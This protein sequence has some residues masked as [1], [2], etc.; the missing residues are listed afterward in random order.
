MC[1][2]SPYA[3][4]YTIEDVYI[5]QNIKQNIR[6]QQNRSFTGVPVKEQQDYFLLRAAPIFNACHMQFEPLHRS[7][8]FFSPR[9]VPGQQSRLIQISW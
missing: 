7:A 2:A 5:K 9:P 3:R 1:V 6:H 8:L 4:C